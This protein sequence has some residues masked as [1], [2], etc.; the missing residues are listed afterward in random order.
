M[1]REGFADVTG[2]TV[3]NGPPEIDEGFWEEKAEE[4]KSVARKL[5]IATARLEMFAIAANYARL[6]RYARH[7]RAA[8]KRDT[9][10]GSADDS[11]LKAD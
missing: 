8:A 4:A 5:T 6:A 9:S 3:A 1:P 10:I 7:R 11:E 2:V